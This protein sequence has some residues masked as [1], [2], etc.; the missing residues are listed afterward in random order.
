MMRNELYSR[1]RYRHRVEGMPA[2]GR[3]AWKLWQML[4]AGATTKPGT[5]GGLPVFVDKEMEGGQILV[6]CTWLSS[7]IQDG[8][9]GATDT[10]H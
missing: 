1:K 6:E 2:S 10:N 3:S 8:N 7:G 4:D 5:F 9:K